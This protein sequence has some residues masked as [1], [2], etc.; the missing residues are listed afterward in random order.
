MARQ[1]Q[2]LMKLL[3]LITPEE[4]S[5]I[6]VKHNEGGRFISLTTIVK[7]RVLGRVYRDFQSLEVLEDIHQKNNI[8]KTEDNLL[9]FAKEHLPTM[10]GIK[11]NAELR[12]ATKFK[13]EG[14]SSA[15]ITDDAD[16]IGLNAHQKELS[17]ELCIEEMNMSAFILEE[18]ERL[19]KS[20]KTLKKIEVVELYSKNAHLNTEDIKIENKSKSESSQKGNLV[21]KKAS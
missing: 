11:D 3:R 1:H 2:L 8:P 17:K 10:D 12:M 16:Y 14:A 21:N 13:S 4:I 7:E 20:Q 5:E 15:L 19:K 18:K 9:D 6:V